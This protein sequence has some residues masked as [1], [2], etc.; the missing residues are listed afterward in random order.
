MGYAKM[1]EEREGRRGESRS[2][3]R[4]EGYDTVSYN[5]SSRVGRVQEWA[6]PG[7]H[8][9]GGR[10]HTRAA[11]ISKR[12]ARAMT[13]RGQRSTR[14]GWRAEGGVVVGQLGTEWPL[15]QGW[16]HLR[17]GR[18]EKTRFAAMRRGFCGLKRNSTCAWDSAWQRPAVRKCGRASA[19]AVSPAVS[20]W[21]V[22]G[23]SLVGHEQWLGSG[24]HC[25]RGCGSRPA[26]G[27]PCAGVA[28]P[29]GTRAD[30]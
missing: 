5:G 23:Q 14:G 27:G 6:Q 30:G 7:Q 19:R 29:A 2:T 12:V 1:V 3:T 28:R 16:R 26:E 10:M 24:G 11:A 25:R 4:G 8:R 21:S 9:H 22:L 15:S 18:G 20:P 17:C 13:S